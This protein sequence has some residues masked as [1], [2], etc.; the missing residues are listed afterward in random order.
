[1]FRANLVLRALV[2]LIQRNGKRD[3]LGKAFRH[4]M[5]SKT[6]SPRIVSWR[7][8]LVARSATG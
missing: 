3:T 1:M 6:G 7:K 2:A 5:R 8:Y 4:D